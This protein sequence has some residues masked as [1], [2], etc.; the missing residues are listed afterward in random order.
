MEIRRVPTIEEIPTEHQEIIV[1]HQSLVA[2][3]SKRNP[4][5]INQILKNTYADGYDITICPPSSGSH[6]KHNNI[7][8]FSMSVGPLLTPPIEE[9]KLNEFAATSFISLH[10]SL[11]P[12]ARWKKLKLSLSVVKSF[13]EIH[14]KQI[15]SP[16]FL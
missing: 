10:K 11:S 4:P 1:P 7:D 15:L 12:A 14:C 3:T 16:V 5:H 13:R 2:N 8:S 6:H 9:P